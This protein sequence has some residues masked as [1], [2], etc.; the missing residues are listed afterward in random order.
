M[1]Q[2]GVQVQ[3]EGG[4]AA[5]EGEP[6]VLVGRMMSP[7]VRRTAVLLDLLRLPFRLRPLAAVAEQE[8]LRAVNPVGRVPAL[9]VDDTVLVDSTAIALTL[10]DRHD[11]DE[12][13]LPRR[14]PAYAEALQLLFVANGALEKFVAAYYEKTRRPAE[15]VHQDWIVLCEGQAASA[16][17]ALETRVGEPFA[18]G[19]SLSYVDLALATA[20]TFMA[21]NGTAFDAARH[22]RLE[23]LRQRCEA[24]PALAARQP[25]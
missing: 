18:L 17:D 14:G 5:A 7:Y 1:A 24:H 2:E 19:G 23:A 15:R 25:G 13:L 16:L 6:M 3:A 10:L 21:A 12:A 9:L 11:P 20:L 22:G 4:R 8:A